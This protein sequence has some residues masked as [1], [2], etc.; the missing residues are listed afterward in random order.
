MERRKFV[1]TCI[2]CTCAF[3]LSVPFAKNIVINKK[4]T[5]SVQLKN[6]FLFEKIEIHLAENCNLGCKYC[7]HFS[8]IADEE[9]YDIEKFEKDIKQLAFATNKS[10]AR[11]KLLGGEPLL[12]PKI[13]DCLDIA[14]KYFPDSNIELT[15]NGI[16]LNSKDKSFWKTMNKN[17]ITLILSVYPVKVD[18]KKVLNNAKKYNIETVISGTNGNEYK[19]IRLGTINSFFKLNLDLSGNQDINRECEYKSYCANYIQG[20]LYPCFVVSNIRHFNKKCQIAERA[21][22]SA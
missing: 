1:T 15:T 22:Q 18:W 17:D 13:N 6:D 20:K 3:A 5:D 16:L 10:V 8:N 14:R 2:C 21:N 19:D 11:L 9:Y 12:H 4:N 7:S